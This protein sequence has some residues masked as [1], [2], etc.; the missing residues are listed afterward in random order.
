LSQGMNISDY[1]CFTGREDVNHSAN[2]KWY[3]VK[4]RNEGSH[5]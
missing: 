1:F 2:K 4:G 5:N 3:C